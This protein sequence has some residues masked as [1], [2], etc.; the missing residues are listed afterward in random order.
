[1]TDKLRTGLRCMA[2][3]AILLTPVLTCAQNCA[4]CYTQF[5]ED[6]YDDPPDS[7]APGS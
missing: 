7:T 3:V 6:L 4:L 2:P 1:M 5:N